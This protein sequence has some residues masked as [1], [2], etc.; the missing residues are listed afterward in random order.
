MQCSENNRNYE[1]SIYK[2][3]NLKENNWVCVKL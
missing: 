3:D 2:V 1:Q